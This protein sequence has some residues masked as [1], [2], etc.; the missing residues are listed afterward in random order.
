MARSNTRNLPGKKKPAAAKRPRKPGRRQTVRRP[1]PSPL[2]RE[3]RPAAALG[4]RAGRL[5]P[6]HRRLLRAAVSAAAPHPRG[7]AGAGRGRRAGGRLLGQV[8]HALLRHRRRD[9][10]RARQPQGPRQPDHGSGHRTASPIRR[11]GWKALAGAAATSSSP[12]STEL[13]RAAVRGWLRTAAAWARR[14]R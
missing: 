14:R 4:R 7:A 1:R 13:P 6:A 12:R 5:R 11:D 8:G 3:P 10:L 9:V 2:V